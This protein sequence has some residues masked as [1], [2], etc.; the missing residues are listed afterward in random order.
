[1][2]A[3]INSFKNISSICLTQLVAEGNEANI[4]HRKRLQDISLEE[5]YVFIT[6][7]SVVILK[8]VYFRR[9]AVCLAD[10]FTSR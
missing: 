10:C 5:I 6:L 1:M 9:T 3:N 8:K 4:S 2:H 7:G